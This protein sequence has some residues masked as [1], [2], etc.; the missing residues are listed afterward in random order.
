MV[1]S[2]L[3]LDSIHKT[4]QLIR[5]GAQ[6]MPD[7]LSYVSVIAEIL[8]RLRPSSQRDRRLLEVARSHLT[9]I[10]R[11]VRRLNEQLAV[12]QEQVTVLTEE[13]EKKPKGK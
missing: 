6:N 5:E 1:Y 12:L 7:P 10:G 8:E 11:Q 3:T 9:E 4:F 13:K 2:K